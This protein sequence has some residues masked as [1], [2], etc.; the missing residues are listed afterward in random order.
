VGVVDIP[1]FKEKAEFKARRLARCAVRSTRRDYR[2]GFCKL[3]IV[4]RRQ[5]LSRAARRSETDR[6]GE[7]GTEH[8]FST[9]FL[10]PVG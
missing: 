4:H 7:D 5:Q 10:A 9:L 3:P 1:A 2:S 6:L 8:Q